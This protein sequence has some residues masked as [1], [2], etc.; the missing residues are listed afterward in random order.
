MWSKLFELVIAAVLGGI[1]TVLIVRFLESAKWVFH[2]NRAKNRLELELTDLKCIAKQGFELT[3]DAYVK[4]WLYQEAEESSDIL[5]GVTVPNPFT[6]LIVSSVLETYGSLYTGEQRIALRN[7]D[8]LVSKQSKRLE[9]LQKS[10]FS[11]YKALDLAE[12]RSV[13]DTFCIMRQIICLK[14]VKGIKS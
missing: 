6:C 10:L 2:S 14:K 13:M 4:S 5:D 1:V 3:H 12:I 9:V 8:F 7:L 11:N